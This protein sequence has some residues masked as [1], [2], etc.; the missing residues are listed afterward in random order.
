ML[1]IYHKFGVPFVLALCLS[2]GK[3]L[4]D[5]RTPSFDDA[6]DTAP[7]LVLV[8]IGAMAVF[9]VRGWTADQFQ[10]A[11]AGDALLAFCLLTI[12][13]ARGRTRATLKSSKKPVPKVGILSGTFE[14]FLGI[15]PVYWTVN[16]R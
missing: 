8:S 15:V 13:G 10:S 5:G 11:A 6:N 16:A 1:N 14:I 3:L 2:L 9:H 4:A 12:R 7:D